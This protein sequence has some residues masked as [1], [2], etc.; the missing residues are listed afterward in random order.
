MRQD[1]KHPNFSNTQTIEPSKPVHSSAAP[2]NQNEIMS[3]NLNSRVNSEHLT[4]KFGSQKKIATSDYQQ[5]ITYSGDKQ[6]N[7][8]LPE[9]KEMI[10]KIP[11]SGTNHYQNRTNEN[12]SS[13]I[14]LYDKGGRKITHEQSFTAEKSHSVRTSYPQ[15]QATFVTT[16]YDQNSINRVNKIFNLKFNLKFKRCFS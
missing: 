15:Q 7:I 10:N 6:K 16:N 11:E 8:S 5:N 1:Y 2:I 9:S 12:Q 13:Y 14:D 4:E 3:G